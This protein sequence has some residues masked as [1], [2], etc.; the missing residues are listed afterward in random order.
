MVGGYGGKLPLPQA[1][2]APDQA[3]A[4]TLCCCNN[5]MVCCVVLF[6][7]SLMGTQCYRL[8]VGRF[9]CASILGRTSASVPDWLLC[10]QVQWP[11]PVV[12]LY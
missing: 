4:I 3:D 9:V 12:Q 8:S 1:T 2:P 11:Y 10:R 7:T 5:M 6:R